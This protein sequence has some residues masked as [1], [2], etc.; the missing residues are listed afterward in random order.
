MNGRIKLATYPK[1]TGK[2]SL[3]RVRIGGGDVTY[4]VDRVGYGDEAQ[5]IYQRYTKD[6]SSINERPF[7]LAKSR[8]QFKT[9][10]AAVT[11][12]IKEQA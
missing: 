5:V 3:V 7:M 8:R 9:L 12:L 1:H 2:T 6:L 4:Y 10:D 11:A